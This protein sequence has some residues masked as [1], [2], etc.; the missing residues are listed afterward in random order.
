MAVEAKRGCGHRKVGGLYLVSGDTFVYCDRL[1]FKLDVCPCCGGGIKQARG[2]TWIQPL[3]LFEGDHPTVHYWTNP[4]TGNDEKLAS[5]GC[6]CLT[7]NPGCPV[8]FP[9]KVF[10]YFEDVNDDGSQTEVLHGKAMLLWIG[11]QH[12]KT[13][14][15]FMAEGVAQGISRRIN[16]IPK[17]FKLG[18]TWVF[19]AHPEAISE[20]VKI[21]GGEVKSDK[22]A[23]IFTA[24]M[25]QV[26]ERIVKQSDYDAWEYANNA[27]EGFYRS[28][29]LE[30]GPEESFKDWLELVYMK[31]K[32]EK[33][34][35]LQRDIDR[36]IT[37]VPVPD[38]DKDHNPDG[39]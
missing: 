1:P 32:R 23:G 3:D 30:K 31:D 19:L 21:D 24:F 22:V 20:N 26:I 15:D 16:A 13:P 37:L 28:F 5:Y 29:D 12:Y 6:E 14:A 8:C 2:T 10:S 9:S 38:D 18:K 11:K 27:K 39:K 36:G 35:K 17:D 4:T 7:A 34:K 25:P 33:Y